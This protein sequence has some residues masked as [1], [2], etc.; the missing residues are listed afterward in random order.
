[1]RETSRFMLLF[2]IGIITLSCKVAKSP[3]DAGYPT[4]QSALEISLDPTILATKQDK[5]ADMTLY[6]V[7]I[8]DHQS[9]LPKKQIR[10]EINAGWIVMRNNN[11]YLSGN[12]DHIDALGVF[13]TRLLEKLN[14]S[15]ESDIAKVFGPG[16]IPIK[17]NVGD[18]IHYF[19]D[20]HIRVVWNLV[21][22]R[23]VA[24]NVWR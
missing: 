2:A 6:G 13:E 1:M 16:G 11:R 24:V 3:T 7:K 4:T 14:I 18:T 19:Q 21:E 10:E 23:V 9:V 8:G 12:T 15:S 17:P 20:R 5:W 22:R